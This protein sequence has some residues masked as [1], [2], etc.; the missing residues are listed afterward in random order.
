MEN[1]F[2]G[3]QGGQSGAGAGQ[4]PHNQSSQNPSQHQGSLSSAGAN[5]PSSGAAAGFE[6][7][8]NSLSQFQARF[9]QATPRYVQDQVFVHIRR[10][11]QS[12]HS[13]MTIRLHPRALGMVSA[14]L[15]FDADKRVRVQLSA[16]KPETLELLQRDAKELVRAL[17]ES[18]IDTEGLDFSLTKEGSLSESA[19]PKL[20]PR[21]EGAPSKPPSA[22]DE[23][24]PSVLGDDEIQ[25]IDNEEDR[26]DIRV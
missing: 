7:M 8:M 14:Q 6:S 17:T 24:V 1:G 13:H 4:N 3:R 5:S 23:A 20:P 15:R 21:A 11:V 19:L 22:V 12:G 16:E 26:L 18:G 10:A 25:I 9:P 2:A